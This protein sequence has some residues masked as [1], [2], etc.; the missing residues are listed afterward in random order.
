MRSGYSVKG[1][2]K[3]KSRTDAVFNIFTGYY[4]TRPPT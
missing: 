2:A 3:H 4:K 1:K